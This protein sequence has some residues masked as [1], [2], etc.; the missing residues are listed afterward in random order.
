MRRRQFLKHCGA[1]VVAQTFISR[2]P[3]VASAIYKAADIGAELDGLVAELMERYQVPGI[4]VAVLNDAKPAHHAW[5]GVTNT[6]TGQTV[7]ERTVFEAASLTKPL[8]AQT[9]LKLWEDG[10]IDLDR[11]LV[12]YRRSDRESADPERFRAITATH[13]L[14]HSTGLPNWH[15]GKRPVRV[16]FDPGTQFSYSGMAF[17]MLQ[18]VVE[19]IT[20]LSFEQYISENLFAPLEMESASLVW[21]EDY[22][23]RLA[24]GH[25]PN[26]KASRQSM[27]KANAASSLVCTAEDYAKFLQA[28]L[29]SDA[30]FPLKLRSETMKRLLN[31][32]QDVVNGIAWGLG[33]GIQQTPEGDSYWH[34]GNNNSRY[35]AFVVWNP[36]DRNGAVV[37]I[38]SGNGLKLCKELIPKLMGGDHPAFNWRMVV[39]R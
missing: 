10:A 2:I 13:V 11:P 26:G 17:V 38:N 18:R 29:D 16:R 21:R 20:K 34:W 35:N 37:M 25:S 36:D 8:L 31:P 22:E 15:R 3:S 6:D 32:E 27:D 30:D 39:G 9:V 23:T 14:T 19:K 24:H 4:S 7:D 33:W 1:A 28:L 5:Y 12:E